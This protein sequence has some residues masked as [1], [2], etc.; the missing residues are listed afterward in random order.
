MLRLVVISIISHPNFGWRDA[1]RLSKLLPFVCKK[2]SGR[3][4]MSRLDVEERS[5]KATA[6]SRTRVQSRGGPQVVETRLTQV[7]GWTSRSTS[8]YR[9]YCQ[10]Q[11]NQWRAIAA[12]VAIATRNPSPSPIIACCTKKREGIAVRGRARL[13]DELR[14]GEPDAMHIQKFKSYE[15]ETDT[16]R[17]CSMTQGPSPQVGQNDDCDTVG[18]D[19][20]A[21]YFSAFRVLGSVSS[22][23]AK[24][25]KLLSRGGGSSNGYGT[26][27]TGPV[28]TRH[29]DCS[30]FSKTNT[31]NRFT[32][33][34]NGT[35]AA[36]TGSE[37]ATLALHTGMNDIPLENLPFLIPAFG[38]VKLGTYDA[39]PSDAFVDLF[40]LVWPLTEFLNEYEEALDG[41]NRGPWE[42]RSGELTL[43]TFGLCGVVGRVWCHLIQTNQDGLEFRNPVHSMHAEPLI[44]SHLFDE[45]S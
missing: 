5:G 27:L 26:T 16:E 28:V 45:H 23:E 31:R 2:E 9:T 25:P 43:S 11:H 39:I 35:T 32:V 30:P 44:P 13:K 7:P 12:R 18:L 29:R 41:D 22:S 36:A 3:P 21:Q 24:K 40:N 4:Q 19:V 38:L 34:K 20:V 6:G 37:V 33:P 8:P 1:P 15:P 17:C 14:G 10:S 42:I